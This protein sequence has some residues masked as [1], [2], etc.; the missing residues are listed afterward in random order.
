MAIAGTP[1]AAVTTDAAGH[2]SFPSVPEGSY[3]FNVSYAGC[4]DPKSVV[5]IVN[6]PETLNVG[7]HR[8]VD[9]Y[10]HRCDLQPTHWVDGT[11][12]VL[13]GDDVSVAVALPFAFS[14]YGTAYTTANV[15]TNGHLSF[16]APSTEYSNVAIPDAAAPNA[17][18]YP[19]WDDF[20]IDASG[21]GVYTATT[22]AAPNRQFV[23]EWENVHPF[24]GTERWDVEAVLYETGRILFQYRRLDPTVTG[25]T[26]HGRDRERRRV[27]PSSSLSTPRAWPRA[28]DPVQAA[29]R[30]AVLKPR[31]RSTRSR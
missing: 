31:D 19:Q 2:Y 6:G 3:T 25:A 20:V 14:H 5:R 22:G 11:A 12:L 18:V 17:A 4:A 10:G 23:I 26:R 9:T 29:A 21:A 7:L 24:N 16:S 28:G 8:R 27:E 15:S 1:F 30:R 13:S